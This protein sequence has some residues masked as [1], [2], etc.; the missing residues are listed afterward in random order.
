MYTYDHDGF[1]VS[2]KRQ[3]VEWGLASFKSKTLS[4][5]TGPIQPIP[6]LLSRWMHITCRQ[7]EPS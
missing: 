4:M 7:P 5:A 6:P 3:M 2:M 1:Y